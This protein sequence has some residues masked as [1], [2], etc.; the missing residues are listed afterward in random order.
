MARFQ[1]V[2]LLLDAAAL[3]CVLAAC[4]GR[5]DN[6]G[7]FPGAEPCGTGACVSTV[8]GSG[9]FGSADGDAATAQFW[10][11]HSVAVDDE[12]R[13]HVADYGGGSATRLIAAGQVSTL[14]DDGIA[15]PHPPEVARDAA[16]TTYLADTYGNRIL[17]IQPG[18]ATTVLAGTGQPGDDD[19]DA[20]SASFSMP[21][22]LAFDAAGALYVAD[23]GNRKIRK[24]TLPRAPG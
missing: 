19:G 20:A 22:G 9:E 16:G 1:E 10:L 23:M 14:L 18:G 6:D 2:A 12:A 5:V 11:P 15:F 13:L 17:R 4:G 21:S 7:G 24:I 3:V 8:A